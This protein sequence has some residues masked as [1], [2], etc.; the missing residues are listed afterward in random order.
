M[1][2][3]PQ[4]RREPGP[5]PVIFDPLKP[6]PIVDSIQAVSFP[7]ETGDEIVIGEIAIE[8]PPS[9]KDSLPEQQ[10]GKDRTSRHLERR[11]DRRQ[12]TFFK[13]TKL[14]HSHGDSPVL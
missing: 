13:V 8:N 9:R 1:G 10:S 12:R 7:K 11:H 2:R 14:W 6:N 4:S 5:T 3:G